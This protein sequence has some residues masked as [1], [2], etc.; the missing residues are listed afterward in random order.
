MRLKKEIL[1]KKEISSTKN[2]DFSVFL[3]HLINHSRLFQIRTI[4][5]NLTF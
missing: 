1:V 4:Y 2:D 5:E 3:I